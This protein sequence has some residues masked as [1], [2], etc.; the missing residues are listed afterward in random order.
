LGAVLALLATAGALIFAVSVHVMLI[1][2][3]LIPGLLALAAITTVCGL[4]AANRTWVERGERVA[5]QVR[6]AM[7]GGIA[8]LALAVAAAPF[9]GGIERNQLR[10]VLMVIGIMAMIGLLTWYSCV[11]L[12]HPAVGDRLRGRS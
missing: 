2:I 6:K 9:T 11:V 3:A 4:L 10:G 12:D 8:F 7:F 5:L 1:L